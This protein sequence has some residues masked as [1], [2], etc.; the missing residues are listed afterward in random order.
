MKCIKRSKQGERRFHLFRTELELWEILKHRNLLR[1][2]DIL[3]GEDY[4]N[5]ITEQLEIDLLDFINKNAMIDDDAT[6]KYIVSQILEGLNHMHKDHIAHL[7]IKLRNVL[8]DDITDPANASNNF[9]V[10][11][12]DFGLAA[13]F[14]VDNIDMKN[15]EWKRIPH[16]DSKGYRPPEVVNNGI[17]SPESDI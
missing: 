7:D 3:L 2:E 13:R 8:C 16:C 10:I 12:S 9:K 4:A 14:E 17:Y 6:R 5:I 1:A 15:P 11:I